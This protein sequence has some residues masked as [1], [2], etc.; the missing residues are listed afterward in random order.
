MPVEL[1]P[2]SLSPLPVPVP[3]PVPVLLVASKK[4]DLV[5]QRPRERARTPLNRLRELAELNNTNKYVIFY[6]EFSSFSR[7]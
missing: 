3:V 7:V 4:L 6:R 2:P 1:P 5:G